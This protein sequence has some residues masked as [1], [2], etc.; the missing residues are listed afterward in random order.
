VRASA[1]H[2]IARGASSRIVERRRTVV[3]TDTEWQALWAAH[4]GTT[5]PAP[6]VDFTSRIVAAVFAGERPSP[7]YDVEI[8]DSRRE[9]ARLT[10]VVDER[11]P[12]A[13]AVNPQIVVTP[14]HI[15]SCP[16]WD[17]EIVFV[18]AD[19]ARPTARGEA[20]PESR[21]SSTGLDPAIAAALAYLAG[22]ISGLLILLAERS[23]RYVRF[24]AW[25]SILGLG[26][27]WAIGFSCYVLAFLLLLVSASAFRVM[28]WMAGVTWGVWV[29]VWVFCLVNAFTG[30]MWK[31]PLVGNFADRRA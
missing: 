27:L 22:P 15:V 3:R 14:C 24:H 28:L 30:A 8:V 9:G 19:A 11:R 23:S 1:L 21:T 16:R 10:F 5:S 31:L 6:P 25:Q 2:T 18:N 13:G 17:G 7:G 4:A 12:D 20:A 29:L 26:G